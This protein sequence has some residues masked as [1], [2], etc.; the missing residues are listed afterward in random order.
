[1]SAA[2]NRQLAIPICTI[3]GDLSRRILYFRFNFTTINGADYLYPRK[4]RKENTME[5]KR[6][7]SRPSPKGPSDF[8]TGNVRIDL[9]KA[10]KDGAQ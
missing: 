4:G 5:I 2:G 9:K 8:F 10:L 7:G 3:A 6:N 1:M